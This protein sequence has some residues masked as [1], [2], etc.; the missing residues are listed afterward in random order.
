[1]K[2]TNSQWNSPI[3]LIDP[4]VDIRQQQRPQ[5]SR[6]MRE[7]RPPRLRN[8]CRLTFGKP[9]NGANGIAGMAR[10]PPLPIGVAAID[11]DP[12]DF[13]LPFLLIPD[14]IPDARIRLLRIPIP[15][16]AAITVVTD[17]WG[18]ESLTVSFRGGVVNRPSARGSFGR[19][20]MF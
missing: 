14:Y 6:C 19:G 17:D 12:R 15:V 16:A 1:M 20:G 4:S 5:L 2:V 11:A 7:P 18:G 3:H 8:L 13:G 10:A 9:L